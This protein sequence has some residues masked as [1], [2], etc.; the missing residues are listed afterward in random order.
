MR[1]AVRKHHRPGDV[2]KQAPSSV[3]WGASTGSVVVQG[4]SATSVQT[5][6]P[7]DPGFPPLEI[8]LKAT[9]SRESS[10]KTMCVSAMFAGV[11]NEDRCSSVRQSL[12]YDGCPCTGLL[13]FSRKNRGR[14]AVMGR[15]DL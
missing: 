1:P 8:L 4:T 13:A 2:G 12:L 10:W 15:H 9:T 5:V 14:C 7:F 3:G 6:P 11:K